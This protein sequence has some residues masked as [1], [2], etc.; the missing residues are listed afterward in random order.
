MVAGSSTR[1]LLVT[2]LLARSCLM[3]TSAVLPSPGPRHPQR[4][5]LAQDY[6]SPPAMGGAGLGLAMLLPLTI[7]GAA[8][9]SGYIK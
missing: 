2:L 9:G 8:L 6:D 4:A 7:L 1:L 3:H 5:K